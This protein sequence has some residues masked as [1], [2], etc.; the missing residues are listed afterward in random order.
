MSEPS[1]NPN[2]HDAPPSPARRRLLQAAGLGGAASLMPSAPAGAAETGAGTGPKVLRYAFRV[3]ETGFD[4]AKLSDLY[5]RIITPHIFEGLYTYDHLARPAK[6]K[7]LTAAAMPEVSSD[8]RVFIIRVQPGIYFASDPAFKGRKRELV[9]EDYVYAL[10][11]FA[12]PANKSPAWGD[13]EEANFVGLTA[14]REETLK[15][16]KP[17]DY[18]RVVP[19]LR[20]LDRYTLRLEVAETRP[21]LVELLAGG[22]LYGAVAREVVEAYGSEIAA[23][24]VGTGPFKLVQWRRSSLIALERNPEYRERYYDAEPAADDAEGQALLARFKGRRLPMIDR[25]EVSIIEENQPRWLS[26][27]NGQQN[28]IERVPEEFVNIAMP[29]G[30]VAPNLVHQGIQGYRALAP[31]VVLTLY[32]MDDPVIGGY[33]P[34]KIALRRA[35]NLALDIPREISLVRRGQGIPAQSIVV[36]NTS[37]YD[38]NFRSE[39]GQYDP[40]RAKAL[41]DIY[42]YVD[43]NGDG[44]REQPNGEPLVIRRAS[45][46]DQTSRA[47]DELWQRDMKAIGIR[48]E[49]EA[50]KWPENL[51]AAQ[52]GSLMCWGVAS[53][54]SQF[55]GQG[56]LGRYYGPLAGSANLARFKNAEFDAIYLK[57]QALP[58]G[59]ERDALFRQAKRIGIAYAPYKCHLHRFITDMSSGEVHGYRRPLF[60]NDWWQY[61]DIEPSASAKA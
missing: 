37:G 43:K 27:L 48:V 5:S 25:V 7:P 32:N 28:F 9:A 15:S 42:G 2:L 19:G 58:D 44:W 12:D 60:W 30:K 17:F 50:A 46:P 26:F 56:A 11:R 45:Q 10:K 35:M 21:R 55:D 3:A 39:M 6:I 16:R 41:L 13:L 23:H 57:M 29:G 4:P 47:L 8:F 31:D 61:V 53:S 36:P 20:T 51:K 59:P 38:P 49:I 33:T 1:P 40:A 52:A 14:L 22:D 34:E 18:D 24:P 54:A